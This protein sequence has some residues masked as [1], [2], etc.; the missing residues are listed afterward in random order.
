VRTCH[1]V[2]TGTHVT[3]DPTHLPLI[4]QMFNVFKID[5]ETSATTPN[6]NLEAVSTTHLEMR[7]PIKIIRNKQWM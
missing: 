2:V 1:A 3:W 5:T 6:S 4:I 7:A